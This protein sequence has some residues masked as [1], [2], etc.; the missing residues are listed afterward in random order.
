MCTETIALCESCGFHRHMHFHHCMAWI[1]SYREI[2]WGFWTP[3]DSIPKPGDCPFLDGEAKTAI[4]PGR[5]P[6]EQCP[7]H[8]IKAAQDKEKKRQKT[9]DTR[10]DAEKI[11]AQRIK[12]GFRRFRP[13]QFGDPLEVGRPHQ[14]KLPVVMLDFKPEEGSGWGRVVGGGSRSQSQSRSG[15]AQGEEEQQQ[16]HTGTRPIPIQRPS[17]ISGIRPPARRQR[18][19]NGPMMMPH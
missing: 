15:S 5:C 1:W 6:N 3:L 14:R 7:G 18:N 2:R 4:L 19:F 10:T 16:Q 11:E 9:M 17:S 8:A 12:L 13:Q